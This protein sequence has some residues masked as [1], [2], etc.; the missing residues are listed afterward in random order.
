MNKA[1]VGYGRCKPG[2][3]GKRAVVPGLLFLIALYWIV[4]TLS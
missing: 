2:S 3:R 1:F 4:A